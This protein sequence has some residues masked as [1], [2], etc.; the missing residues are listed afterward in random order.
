[1]RPSH[2]NALDRTLVVVCRCLGAAAVLVCLAA[3]TPLPNYLA[4]SLQAEP[5]LGP[6]DAIVVLG[7][8]VEPDGTLSPGSLYRVTQGIKLYK[9]RLAPLIVFSGPAFGGPAAEA[10]VA[11]QL[12]RDLR[13][14]SEQILTETGARTTP[15][16]APPIPRRPEPQAAR[17]LPP[18]TDSEHLTRS[19]ALFPP[20]RGPGGKR[21]FFRCD[22]PSG[23]VGRPRCAH[24]DEPLRRTL[25]LLRRHPAPALAPAGA[26]VLVMAGTREGSLILLGLLVPGCAPT[27]TRWRR[28]AGVDLR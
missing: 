17:R 8:G 21:L 2:R 1:M 20:P 6:A 10:E 19:M 11:A 9:A 15:E 3:L 27:D 24:L 7:S 25:R 26:G 4:R 5:R 23:V 16:E 22:L 18:A 12:A 28:E 13:V 14:P